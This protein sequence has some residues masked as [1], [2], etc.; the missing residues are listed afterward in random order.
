MT[1]KVWTLDIEIQTLHLGIILSEMPFNRFAVQNLI[2]NKAIT[3]IE[4]VSLAHSLSLFS[5]CL[6][7]LSE[8]KWA[9]NKCREYKS[10][11]RELICVS[12]TR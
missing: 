6:T 2:I 8:I 5:L 10:E 9:K 1:I 12:K 11:R 4:L 3:N 7:L